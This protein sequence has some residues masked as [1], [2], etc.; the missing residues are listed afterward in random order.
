M[1]T[2]VQPQPAA[3]PTR[4]TV[5]EYLDYP[6]R[7][8]SWRDRPIELVHGEVRVAAF[9]AGAHALI[10]SNIFSA[11]WEFVH[12]RTLGRVFGDNTG[13]ALPHRGDTIRG[14]DVSFVRA[15][16]LPAQQPL[17]GL[18][19]LAPDLAVEVLSPSDTYGEVAEKLEDFFAGGTELVWLVDARRWR[20][21]A[22]TPD[23]VR[24]VYMEG[25]TAD[26][27][28]VLLEFRMDIADVFAGVARER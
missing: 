23:G 7:E 6:W 4:M 25:T 11:L 9:P 26:A 27:A 15:G 5:E 21:E 16:R 17:R 28:P 3:V 13:Y 12:G 8:T 14:P 18:F 24:R 19:S 10:V 2:I 20:I 22:V 1:A